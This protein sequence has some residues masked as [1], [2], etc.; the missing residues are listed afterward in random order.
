[1][2]ARIEA[3]WQLTLHAARLVDAGGE[4]DCAAAMAKLFATET[5]T[6]VRTR[7]APVRRSGLH[8]RKRCSALLSRLQGTE[9]GEGT[10]EIQRETIFRH[11]GR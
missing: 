10:S 3:A 1:M 2:A 8:A 9:L 6:H 11:I 7:A 5:C 4:F